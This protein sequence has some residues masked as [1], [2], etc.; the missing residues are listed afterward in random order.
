MHHNR[1]KRSFA[2]LLTMAMLLSLCLG[3]AGAQYPCVGFA[4]RKLTVTRSA[5]ATG[6]TLYTVPAGD[7]VYIT[8]DSGDYYIIEYDGQP[9]YAAKS[10]VRLAGEVLVNNPDGAWLGAYTALRQGDE[11]QLVRELQSALIEAGFLSGSAD[12]KY[13]QRTAQAVADFQAV[14]GL[15]NSGYADIATQGTLYETKI[16]NSRGKAV[17]VTILPSVDGLSVSSGKTGAPEEKNDASDG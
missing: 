1:M 3:A 4:A 8:G 9:G 6:E 17:S 10:A 13:G 2:F 11:G 14:N 15:N 16:T 5:S 7:A 12:G